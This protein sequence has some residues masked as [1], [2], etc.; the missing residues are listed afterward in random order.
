VK[1]YSHDL[2]GKCWRWEV[3]PRQVEAWGVLEVGGLRLEARREV[4]VKVEVEQGG[5]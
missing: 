3:G 1:I 4:E 2:P 5:R